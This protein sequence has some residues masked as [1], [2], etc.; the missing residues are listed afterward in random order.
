MSAVPYQPRNDII[1]KYYQHLDPSNLLETFNV[2]V[3]PINPYFSRIPLGDHFHYVNYEH[4]LHIID[5]SDD[6][7]SDFPF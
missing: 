4:S 2:P 6:T 1:L 5:L 3:I 7:F